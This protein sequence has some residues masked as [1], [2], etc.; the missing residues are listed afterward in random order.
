MFLTMYLQFLFARAQTSV[1]N[2]FNVI[3]AE[4][5]AKSHQKGYDSGIPTSKMKCLGNSPGN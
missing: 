3:K 4:N 1:P 5:K 2:N